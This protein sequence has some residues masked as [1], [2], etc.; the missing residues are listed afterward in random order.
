MRKDTTLSASARAERSRATTRSALAREL[1]YGAVLCRFWP[2]YIAPC[3]VP[4]PDYP[5][6]LCVKSPM[7]LL[8]WR[9][10]PDEAMLFEHLPKRDTP[11]APA[12]RTPI[13][14]H[15]VERDR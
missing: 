9:V 3:K 13:L 7:G 5:S 1:L 12:D 4:N 11:T 2:A 6:V 8:T 15:L 14:L 10:S